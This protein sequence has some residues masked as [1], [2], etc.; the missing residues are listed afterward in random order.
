MPMEES[1]IL[2]LLLTSIQTSTD[3]FKIGTAIRSVGHEM[4][5]LKGPNTRCVRHEVLPGVQYS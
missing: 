5:Q 4:F 2:V 1:S 3:G